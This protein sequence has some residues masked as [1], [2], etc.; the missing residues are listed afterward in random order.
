MKGG[1]F[2]FARES[3][4][5]CACREGKRQEAHRKGGLVLTWAQRQKQCVSG[6]DG[7]VCGYSTA[8]VQQSRGLRKFTV[9]E[10]REFGCF[11]GS[12]PLHLFALSFPQR[13]LDVCPISLT[14]S[15]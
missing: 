11:T 8:S 2:L 10:R 12:G 15:K 1:S 7:A 9:S 3:N 14:S 13:P 4:D 5:E 6:Q